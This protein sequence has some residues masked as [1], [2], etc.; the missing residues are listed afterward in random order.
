MSLQYCDL[1]QLLS[2]AGFLA[3]FI[4][5]TLQ[6]A[7][8]GIRVM[9]LVRGK[10]WPEAV[11]EGLFLLAFPL[12]LFDI[13]YFAWP[14]AT[15]SASMSALDPGLLVPGWARSLGAALQLA[16]IA[17]FAWSLVSFGNSWRVGVD[18]AAPGQLVTTGIFAWSRNPI[19]LSMDLFLVGA[20][21]LTG[22]LIPALFAVVMLLGFHR[23]IRTEERFLADR[24]GAAYQAYR[25]RV[26]RYAGFTSIHI[27]GTS[28]G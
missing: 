18:R 26:G 6:L 27:R 9:N 22:R 19:F 13:V 24:Y 23:Q 25:Q 8:R 5:R 28:P 3:L 10:P 4:G 15:A 16:A 12:W 1:F 2:M 11:L 7:S 20:A 14:A 17:M 21:L